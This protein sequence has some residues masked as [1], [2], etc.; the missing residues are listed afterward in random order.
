MIFAHTIFNSSCDVCYNCAS[1]SNTCREYA[2]GDER[3]PLIFLRGE[4]LGG[5]AELREAETSG[6]LEARFRE[7]GVKRRT[8][9]LADS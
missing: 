4:L 1:L 5:A 9:R 6:Q 7:I 2:G 3:I 8:R